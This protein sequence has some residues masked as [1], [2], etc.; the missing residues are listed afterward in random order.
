MLLFEWENNDG[1]IALKL[2]LRP[3]D[4]EVRDKIH[5]AIA[6]RPEFFPSISYVHNGY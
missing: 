2:V 6:G 4:S 5:N 1:K 3:G